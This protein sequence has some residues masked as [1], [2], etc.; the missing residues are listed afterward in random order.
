MLRQRYLLL[1]LLSMLVLSSCS[2]SGST[3]SALD[4]ASTAASAASPIAGADTPISASPTP[5][6]TP[7]DGRPVLAIDVAGE[8]RPISRRL[9][10][11][12]IPAWLGPERLGSS[13]M[14]AFTRALGSPFLRLPGG[15]W[16]NGYNWLA[17]ENGDTEGCY[18]TWAARPTDFLNFVRA[19]GS[20]AMWTV[21]I[22]GTAQ[23]AAALVAFFNGSVT[24]T[25]PIGT[26]PRGRDWKT[27]GDWARLRA[28]HGNPEALPIKFWEVGNEVYGGKPD[29]G[30]SACSPY[31]WEDVWTCDAAEYV[32]G[33]GEGVDY[34]QGYLDFRKAML[35]VDPTIMV[36]AVGVADPNSWSNWGNKVIG[37]AGEN[38]D[39]Y[40]VHL[41]AYDQAPPANDV[42]LTRPQQIWASLIDEIQAAAQSYAGGRRVSVAVTEYNLVAF[43]DLDARQ[44]MRQMVNALVMADMIGQMASHGVD[45]AAQWALMNGRAS[46]GTDY[47]LVDPDDG[48]RAPQYYALALWNRFGDALL[49]L[50]TSLSAEKELSAYAGRTNDGTLTVLAINK[51]GE[52]IDVQLQFLGMSGQ[53]K[54]S[55]DVVA[56]LSLDTLYCTLNGIAAP[57]ADLSDAPSTQLGVVDAPL[58]YSFAP[59]SISLLTLV[60]LP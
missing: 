9:F 55:V 11:T 40:V 58:D 20:E 50:T 33:K 4:P 34:H 16:S 49:T 23:E 52:P 47:G 12:N 7:A 10:G 2:R 32:S 1:L 41:Y 22:N 57:A 37:V 53:Y 46:N 18:W 28:E 5:L 56:G 39:F 35:A 13:Q 25:T 38:L 45:M 19:T 17:C 59:Y 30:G 51:T 21:S 15:S 6:P 3:P 54:A 43:Q 8:A 36:G 31:G 14:R 48:T 60:P 26:D 42:I 27:V 44:S 29:S 24:D